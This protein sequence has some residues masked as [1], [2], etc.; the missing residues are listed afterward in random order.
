MM[1]PTEKVVDFAEELNK[2]ALDFIR[3]N[4]TGGMVTS[5]TFMDTLGVLAIVTARVLA[6]AVVLSSTPT[7]GRLIESLSIFEESLGEV[8]E[9]MFD[10]FVL[11]KKTGP[12]KGED[13]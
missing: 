9:H 12:I 13:V 1:I 11:E 10:E 8:A 3:E 2:R 7:K 4:T 5:S 6:G